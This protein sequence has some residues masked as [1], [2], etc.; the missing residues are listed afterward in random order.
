MPLVIQQTHTH[1][2]ILVLGKRFLTGEHSF[3]HCSEQSF[4]TAAQR[5][6]YSKA[7]ALQQFSPAHTAGRW[8]SDSG[9][10]LTNSHGETKCSR[11]SHPAAADRSPR[12][13]RK[14]RAVLQ[15]V[16]LRLCLLARISPTE[17]IAYGRDWSIANSL[18]AFRSLSITA[19]I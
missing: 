12:K 1:C 7:K 18:T 9:A 14:G 5:F 16:L 8:A 4:L 10:Q 13:P 11:R 17:L 19:F 6:C 2:S 15:Q 3:C